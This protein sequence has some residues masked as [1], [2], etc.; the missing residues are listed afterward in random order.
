[1][2]IWRA[3]ADSLLC[4]RCSRHN[5]AL[6]TMTQAS[7]TLEPHRLKAHIYDTHDVHIHVPAQTEPYTT[8]ATSGSSSKLDSTLL[9]RWLP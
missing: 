4:T 8:A 5:G 7:R 9:S 6:Y 3:A 1:M 2:S